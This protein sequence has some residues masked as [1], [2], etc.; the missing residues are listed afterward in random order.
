M[1]QLVFIVLA[2]FFIG[3]TS[4]VLGIGGGAI[5]VPLLIYGFKLTMNQAVGTSLAVIIP[6]A[7]CA[8]FVHFQHGNVSLKIFLSLFIFTILGGIVG[9]HLANLLPAAILKRIFALFLGAIAVKM[10]FYS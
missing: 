8:G 7:L 10:F 3:V 4:G 2:G 9:A 5:L 1:T 6:T